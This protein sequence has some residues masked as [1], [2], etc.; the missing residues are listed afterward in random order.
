MQSFEKMAHPSVGMKQYP[1]I[2]SRWAI[3]KWRLL[4][5]F[6]NTQKIKVSCH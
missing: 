2:Q 6:L 1:M 5:W 3:K 4:W